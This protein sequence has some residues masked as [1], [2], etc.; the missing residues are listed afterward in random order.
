MK[1]NINLFQKQYSLQNTPQKLRI[2]TNLEKNNKG[3]L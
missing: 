2:R 3:L 1:G